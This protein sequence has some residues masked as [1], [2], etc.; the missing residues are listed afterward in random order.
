MVVDKRAV[1]GVVVGCTIKTGL[2]VC[3]RR[4]K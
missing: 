2:G 1:V 3:V 4:G